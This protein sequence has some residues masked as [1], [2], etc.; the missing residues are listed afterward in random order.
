MVGSIRR[1]CSTGNYPHAERIM[2]FRAPGGRYRKARLQFRLLV[3]LRCGRNCESTVSI[4]A[5]RDGG[6]MF[7]RWSCGDREGLSIKLCKARTS[8]AGPMFHR[9]FWRYRTM[10]TDKC[11][12]ACCGIFPL[13]NW[14]PVA[15]PPVSIRRRL[16][17]GGCQRFSQPPREMLPS[18][19]NG[20]CRLLPRLG[21]QH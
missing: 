1:N 10:P 8:F 19:S 5:E 18:G 17:L 20:S 11:Q 15:R 14:R 6:W 12:Q 21:R 16:K 4:H 2:C 9:S 3:S 13:A 7:K